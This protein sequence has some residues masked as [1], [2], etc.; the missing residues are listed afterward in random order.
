MINILVARS[1][2]DTSFCRLGVSVV[3][4][5]LTVEAGTARFGKIG[6]VLS[7]DETFSLSPSTSSRD[8]EGFLVLDKNGEGRLFVFECVEDG[9]LFEPQNY[10]DLNF[11]HHLFMMRVP[12]NTVDFDAVEIMV[13]HIMETED[14]K[15]R[16][17]SDGS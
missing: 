10:P 17:V 1:W 16:S 4:G 7:E 13:M 15:P 2:R 11:V 12:A 9:V 3:G 5:I 8:I 14:P 6:F